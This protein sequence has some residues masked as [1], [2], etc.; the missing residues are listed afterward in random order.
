M[1]WYKA[2]SI[3]EKLKS[4][5]L[6]WRLLVCQR[7]WEF[8]KKNNHWKPR[9]VKRSFKYCYGLLRSINSNIATE[10]SI[11]PQPCMHL[12]DA[13]KI[14][15]SRQMVWHSHSNRPTKLANN[16]LL[17]RTR[18]HIFQVWIFNEGNWKA[19]HRYWHAQRKGNLRKI[20]V[21]QV[22][23]Q[24]LESNLSQSF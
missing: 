17:F 23:F 4:W 22:L 3:L 18:P 5:L 10:S 1:R 2:K 13:T 8:W 19:R 12:W 7:V 16:R 9:L 24:V 15:L 21:W 6:S 11:N 14:R 20:N